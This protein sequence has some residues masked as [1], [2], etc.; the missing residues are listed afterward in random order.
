MR[1]LRFLWMF[2]AV[3]GCGSE[4]VSPTAADTSVALD[5]GAVALDAPPD[6]ASDTGSAED[7][8]VAPEDAVV[9]PEDAG[10]APEDTGG[11]VV[12]AGSVAD[13]GSAVVDAGPPRDR[14]RA[15]PYGVGVWTGRVAGTEGDARVFFPDAPGTERYPLVVFAHGFQMAVNHYDALLRHVASHGYVVASVHYPGTLLDVD[16]RNVSGALSAAR[17]AFAGAVPGFAGRADVTRAVAMGHSLGAK[18][19]AM[20]ALADPGFVAGLALDPVDDSPPF[21]APSAQ[22]PSVAPEMM[23]GLRVP[24]GLVGATQSRCPQLGQACAPE[25]HD[26]R[27]FAAAAPAT[28]PHPVWALRNF[29]HMDFADPGCGFVCAAC[30][31]GAAPIDA[32]V[33]A[34]RGLAVAFLDQYVRGDASA[35]GWID[36]AEYRALVLA[37]TLWDGTASTLPACR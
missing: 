22:R 27:Q 31:R 15:G 23:S 30:A 5:T 7:T 34:L 1:S 21:G 4:R 3:V 6:D 18:G 37:G 12:D 11:A 29:G 33:A 10:V 9:A 13:T 25:P 32:R 28:V 17:R 20:A 26:Y 19:A 2:A 16:H 24:L 14:T 35:R 36:G 8:G